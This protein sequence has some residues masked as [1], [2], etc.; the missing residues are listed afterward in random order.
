MKYSSKQQNKTDSSF[1]TLAETAVADIVD[2]EQVR[3]DDGPPLGDLSYFA[4][5]AGLRFAGRHLLIDIYDGQRLDE[6]AHVEQTLRDA[7]TACKATL[8]HINLHHF[9]ENNGVSGVAVLA[10]SHISIHTWP[11]AGYAAL[12]IFMC[13]NADP[14]KALPVLQAAFSPS[15]LNVSEHKRGIVE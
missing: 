6:L 11:E 9:T 1:G 14:F 3:K 12:D 2:L 13:G 5:E 7:V 4:N 10:E 8:L 15:K